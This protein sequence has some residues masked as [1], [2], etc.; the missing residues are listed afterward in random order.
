MIIKLIFK[1]FKHSLQ[2][3]TAL[4]SSPEQLF[5]RKIIFKQMLI[6]FTIMSKKHIC[7]KVQ[8]LRQLKYYRIINSETQMNYHN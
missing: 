8:R 2:S 6:L 1:H 5:E 4:S 3:L 7:T